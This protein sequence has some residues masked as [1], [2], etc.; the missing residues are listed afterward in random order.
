MEESNLTLK[1]GWSRKWNV[2]YPRTFF[3]RKKKVRGLFWRTPVS[4]KNIFRP[5]KSFFFL[6][7]T[8][9]WKNRKRV[10]FWPFFD[11]P[12]KGRKRG[13][14][15]CVL[16]FFD[17]RVGLSLSK[18]GGGLGVFSEYT[19][20]G[21]SKRGSKKGVFLD[22]FCDFFETPKNEKS[23]NIPTKKFFQ[24]KNFLVGSPGT[25]NYLD[26]GKTILRKSNWKT[27]ASI[28]ALSYWTLE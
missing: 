8:E 6:K 28:P 26:Q 4:P 9:K 16:P 15:S 7:K 24:G 17:K 27:M 10:V 13:T 21:G 14:F 5:H 19:K 1:Y 11:P 20:R 3:S 18:G 23:W 25:K 2:D 12:Q 22:P